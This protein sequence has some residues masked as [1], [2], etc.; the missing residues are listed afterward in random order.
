MPIV[1]ILVVAVAVL[2]LAAM[3]VSNLKRGAHSRRLGE[4]ARRARVEEEGE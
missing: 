4:E 1:G 2:L 3:I